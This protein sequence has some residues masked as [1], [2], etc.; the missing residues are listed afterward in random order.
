MT[1]ITEGIQ[2]NFQNSSRST[3]D[4][5]K[6][7]SLALHY[8]ARNGDLDIFKRLLSSGADP[9]A[10]TNGGAT[11]LHRAA[12]QGHDPIVA[13]IL[14]HPKLNPRLVDCDGQTALHRAA[15]NGHWSTVKL[16]LSA[17]HQHLKLVTDSHSRTPLDLV[18]TGVQYDP[19]RAELSIF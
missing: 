16:I 19:L 4:N 1:E 5:T 2:V 18:P 10:Q 14:T 9:N 11:A 12:M 8:A 15:Q 6:N 7:F 17:G 13:H 3:F